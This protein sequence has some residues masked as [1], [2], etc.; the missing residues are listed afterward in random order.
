MLLAPS[1]GLLQASLLIDSLQVY[2]APSQSESRS[3]ATRDTIS[4][5]LTS[6][7]DATTCTACEVREE[8]IFCVVLMLT[9]AVSPRRFKGTCTRRQRRFCRCHHWRLCRPWCM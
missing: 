2:A 8:G 1:L 5:I 6:I 7:E 4:D 3:L 9:F